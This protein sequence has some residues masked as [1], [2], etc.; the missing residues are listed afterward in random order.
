MLDCAASYLQ[1][2]AKSQPALAQ[3]LNPLLQFPRQRRH[4]RNLLSRGRLLKANPMRMQKETAQKRLALDFRRRAVQRVANH[5][6]ADA[7]KVYADL[8]RAP[9]SDPHLQQREALEP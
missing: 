8:V 2:Y 7:G 5:R 3:P 1:L 9:R 4:N 6:V